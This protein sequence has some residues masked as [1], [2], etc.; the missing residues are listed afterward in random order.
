MGAPVEYTDEEAAIAHVWDDAEHA[1]FE[2]ALGQGAKVPPDSYLKLIEPERDVAEEQDD[3][4]SPAEIE[5]MAQEHV[6]PAAEAPRDGTIIAGRDKTGSMAHV[7][8]RTEPALDPADDDP[9]WSRVDDGD[10]FELVD[11]VPSIVDAEWVGRLYGK[12]H[13]NNQPAA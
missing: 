13:E 5:F 4:P 3:G 11:W 6:R 12:H 2:A 10:L 9:H 8:W 7:R 1:A